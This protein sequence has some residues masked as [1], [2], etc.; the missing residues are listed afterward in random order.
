MLNALILIINHIATV[1]VIFQ[2]NI[3]KKHVFKFSGKD[4]FCAGFFALQHIKFW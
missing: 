2:T 1:K 4:I 3:E